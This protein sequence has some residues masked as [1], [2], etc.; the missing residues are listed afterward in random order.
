[1]GKL[2]TL[3]QGEPTP[4]RADVLA[5]IKRLELVLTTCQHPIIRKTYERALVRAK[6]SIGL[7]GN[8]IEPT[9]RVTVY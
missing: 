3:Q 4:E 2:K 7:Y 6:H 8:A 9:K 1:M 5:N